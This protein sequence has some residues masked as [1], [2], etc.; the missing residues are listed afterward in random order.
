MKL[1]E[2]SVKN[3]LIV[4]CLSI[5]LVVVGLIALFSL[6]REAFPNFSF[7]IVT[8]RTDYPGASPDVIEKRIS[9]PLEK[10]L[11]EVDDIDEMGSVSVEGLSLIILQLDPDAP[12]KARLFNDIRQA[13]E[14]V[15]DLPEDL[16]NE[17]FVKEMQIRNTPI[18]EVSLSGNLDEMKLREWAVTLEEEILD[19]KGVA[20]VERKGVHD[21]EIWV[22]VDPLKM[23][24]YDLAL[25][26]VMSS[27][28]NRN[29]NIPG[30][31]SKQARSELILRTTGE[32]ETAADVESVIIRANEEGHWVKVADIASVSERLEEQ[33]VI[34][35]T[36]GSRAMNLLVIKKDKADT[37]RLMEKLET[38]LENFKKKAPPELKIALVNDISYYIKRRLGVLISNGWIGLILVMIP[39]VAFLS[40]RVALGAAIGM[41]V[42]FLTAIAAMQFLG[43]SINL[44]SMFGL[45]MVLGMLVDE[46]LVVA[47][48]IARYL[49]EGMGHAEAAIRG[50]AEV[51]R[52]I[53][54]V[55]LTTIIAFLPLLFMTGIFGKFIGEIP[56]VVM[57]TLAAS[58][59][60]AL[61]IL[62]SH[63]SDLNRPWNKDHV[64]YK[65]RRQHEH[66]D[67]FRNYYIRSLKFCLRHAK[68]TSL[69]SIGM[70]TGLILY[71][72]FGMRFIL[73]PQKGIEAFFLRAEVELGTPLK[74]T[75]TMMLPLEKLIQTLPDNELDHFVTQIGI[76]QNDP[77][78]PFT[79]R[80][81]HLAQIQ[82]YLSPESKREREA[83]EIMDSLRGPLNQFKGYKKLSFDPVRPGPPVGKPVAIK[84]RG[85]DYA[86]MDEIAAIFKKELHNTHGVMDVKDDHEKGKGE[87]RVEV[88]E[89]AA[90]QAGLTHMDI[91]LTVRQAFE[92]MNATTIRRGDEEIDVVV[93]YPEK[94][95]YNI[96]TL[97]TLPILNR[98]GNLVP[99]NRVAS[100]KEAD[101]VTV[102]KHAEGKRIVTVTANIDEDVTTSSELNK[103]LQ[104]KYKFL[105]EKYPDYQI[106]YGGEAED[107]QESLSSLMSALVASAFLIF[108]ILLITFGSMTQTA[109]LML[110]IPFGTVGVIIGFFLLGEP[111]TF[112]AMLGVVGLTGIVVDGGILLFIFI[113][114]EMK[115]GSDLKDSIINA[116]SV[117]M[118]AI[119]LTTV[120]TVLGILPV[121]M[122][123]GGSDPFIRP[124]A[125]A[126]NWGLAISLF[127][128][129]YAIPSIYYVV[130]GA[131]EKFKNTIVAKRGNSR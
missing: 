96:Q 45:I 124:M 94:S 129:L 36:D 59:I 98:M 39:M 55:V 83:N 80:G 44:I 30:G 28:A 34:S 56:K 62:P 15:Q 72:V 97:E 32:L 101:G 125:L 75:E 103:T 4:N 52:A 19:M 69:I 112:L 46:D 91:G 128:T 5:F 105:G 6:E 67:K 24:S 127:F 89:K 113:N 41:P 8:V 11:K 73:F 38:L 86:I 61:I 115:K 51:S 29:V 119:F 20:S 88:I 104:E 87:L 74:V 7:D 118:R 17:P 12:D 107:T 48:N 85:D 93:R 81:S 33:K 54:S 122:G 40:W 65:R 42:A 14:E 120:T 126:L 102:I 84:I 58:L 77:G 123:L 100:L 90:Y 1:S 23:S 130:E 109:V 22:E 43:L 114:S 106:S 49:E 82:V 9:I 27:L 95:R 108:L 79:S 70:T 26:Q 57:I 50:A 47:E 2:Y 63:L 111:F 37:I 68:V 71:A 10:E 116:C 18:V 99:L 25:S 60:E 53:V 13:V 117:R 16:E 92:G 78:D 31:L 76:V 131:T 3:S 66:F 64:V 121:S 35:R 21:R 110:V